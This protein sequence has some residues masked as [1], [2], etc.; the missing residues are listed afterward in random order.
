MSSLYKYVNG[1]CGSGKTYTAIN[2]ISTRVKGGETI[3]YAT[4]TIKLLKQTQVAL[5]ALISCVV[6]GI[7][8][9]EIDC[10]FVFTVSGV[11][12]KI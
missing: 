10:R 6:D 5:E 3:I 2:K 12:N 4:E 7:A 11:P 8:G 1:V 9:F